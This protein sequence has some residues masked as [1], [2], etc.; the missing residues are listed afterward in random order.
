MITELICFVFELIVCFAV[1]LL[2]HQTLTATERHH[3]LHPHDLL[4]HG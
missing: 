2:G 1:P 4:L 3:A